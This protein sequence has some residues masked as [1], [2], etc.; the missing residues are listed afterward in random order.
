M[1]LAIRTNLNLNFYRL[2]PLALMFWQTANAV[3]DYALAPLHSQ[4]A[5]TREPV[6]LSKGDRIAGYEVSSDYD[7]A[8]VHPVRGTV[9]PHYGIDVATPTGTKLIAPTA[10]EVRCWYDPAGGGEVADVMPSAGAP[11][12]M[13]HLSTCV[14]GHYK[15]GQSFALTG[16]SGTGTGAHLDARRMDKA[17]PSKQD[18]EPYLTGKLPT[19]PSSELSD[20][21]LICSI[22][23]AEGTRDLNCQPNQ[24]YVGHIDPGN[25]ASNLGSFS[26][27]HGAS[28]P[29]EADKKQ[30]LRLRQAEVDIQQQAEQKFGRP[31]SKAGLAAALDL[32][33]QAPKAGDDIVTHLPSATPTT[34]QIVE[35]RSQSYT[36]PTT[37][38]LDA[39]G[40]GNEQAIRADQRRRT[41]AVSNALQSKRLESLND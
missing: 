13:L 20:L 12:K 37:G 7:L 18:I 28:S 15:Q 9:E 29:A 41:A 24:H 4:R 23:A 14:S 8:R 10:I 38:K 11:M 21:E 6:Y 1:Q 32:W 40:L 25:G 16:S 19:R 35:A 33:N 22:G 3:A 27:Q 31:L 26:Y 34:A 39:P 30:M 17:E 2:V 5:I 36:D